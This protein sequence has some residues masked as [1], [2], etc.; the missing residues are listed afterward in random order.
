MTPEKQKQGATAVGSGDLLGVMVISLK[1]LV[2]IK[3]N[4]IWCCVYTS[5]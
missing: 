3:I 2:V 4:L 5:T 1:R